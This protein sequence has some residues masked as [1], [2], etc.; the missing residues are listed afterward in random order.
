MTMRCH[1]I[2]ISFGL[3]ADIERER[4]EVARLW[5]IIARIGQEDDVTLFQWA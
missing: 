2:R 4:S 1:A 5:R 3:V